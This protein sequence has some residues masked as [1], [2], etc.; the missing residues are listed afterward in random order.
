MA[1]TALTATAVA[2]GGTDLTAV[3]VAAETTDG[4]SFAWAP[5]RV[6]WVLNGDDASLTVT[7]PTPATVGRSALAIGDASGT[8]AAA[9]HKIFGPYGS[10]YVQSDGTVHINYTGTT[11]TNVTVVVLDT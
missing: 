1:R 11:I 2:E 10:E 9:A 5:H 3:D 4:N 7:V 6:F 8:I